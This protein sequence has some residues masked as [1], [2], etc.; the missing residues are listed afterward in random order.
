M[1]LLLSGTVYSAFNLFTNEEVAIKVDMPDEE[2]NL[3]CA[4]PYEK[5]IYGVLKDLPGIPYIRW[6]GE[7]GG[8]T[9]MVM[10]KLGPTLDHLRR[11][12]RGRFSMKT[13][14]MLALQMI[15][16]IEL[17]HSRGIIVRDIKPENF[18]MGLGD[19]R[20]VLH[21]F[22]FGI[23]KLYVDP[24]SG[25]HMPFRDGRGD[26][27]TPR[28]VSY[29]AQFGRELG[30]RDDIEALGTVLLL[31]WHGRLPWQGI[32]APDE[33]AKKR[34]MGEMKAGESM[35][36]LLARSPSELRVLVEHARSLDFEDRPDYDMVRHVFLECLRREGWENDG[37]FD[38]VDGCLL[39]KGTLIPEEY[40]W[41]EE[42]ANDTW[43]EV[44][45]NS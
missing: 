4:L 38:W 40:V 36:E 17:I 6:Y 16:R 35:R 45:V 13:I 23:S 39:E 8:A 26:V 27:G 31:F 24:T 42:V 18:A 15:S 11:F 3:P 44:M 30:R 43:K 34:R 1:L 7:E 19:Y 32:Y 5:K 14:C 29:N 2:L 25:R 9:V 41:D 12:C 28:Y 33:Q 20:S 10:D 21:L 22:D 37:K